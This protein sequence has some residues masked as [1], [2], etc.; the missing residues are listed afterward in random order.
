[1]IISSN[2]FSAVFP[3]FD[4]VLHDI[5]PPA[6]VLVRRQKVF[7]CHILFVTFAESL[8][9]SKCQLRMKPVCVLQSQKGTRIL[10]MQ[11]RLLPQQFHHGIGIE[12]R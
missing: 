9:F 2:D 10:L 3:V 7:E 6:L 8:C 12:A 1:M 5:E 4:H 11:R